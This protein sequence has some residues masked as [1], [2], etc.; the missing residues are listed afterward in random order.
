MS[1]AKKTLP[2]FRCDRL[3]ATMTEHACSRRWLA[4]QDGRTTPESLALCEP[5]EIGKRHAGV[6]LETAR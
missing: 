6:M 4:A 5:C 2:M 3:H 1:E